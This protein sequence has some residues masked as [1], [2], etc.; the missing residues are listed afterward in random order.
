[1][2]NKYRLMS[3]VIVLLSCT[4]AGAVFIL[5][6][7]RIEAIY[8]ESA[9]SAILESKKAHL[10]HTVKNQITRIEAARKRL[11]DDELVK[12]EIARD[13]RNA[14]YPM[15]SY[16]WVTEVLNYDGGEDYAIRRIHPNLRDTEGQF[17]S[18][19]MTDIKGGKPYQTELEGVKNHGS[20]FLSYYFKGPGSDEISEKVTYAE[21]YRDFN[22]IVSMGVHMDDIVA[23]VE[24]ANSKSHTLISH[25]IAFFMLAL[26]VLTGISALTVLFLERKV[27]FD[28]KKLLEEEANMDPLTG[29]LSRRAGARALSG[30]FAAFRGGERESPMVALFD[31]DNFKNINDVCGHGGGDEVL[32]QTVERVDGAVRMSDRLFRWGG[33][34]F[35]LI[36]EGVAPDKAAKVAENVVRA[37]ASEAFFTGKRNADITLSMGA[38]FFRLG[39]E[40]YEDALKRADEALYE[41]KTKG[42]NRVE[43][44]S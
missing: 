11:G 24:D 41:A 40:G 17:L 14:V 26:A 28:S 21:L 3:V 20:L 38:A 44:A 13:I 35:L 19:E 42:R 18:T 37:V 10:R 8:G 33:D 29:A 43:V 36:M 39:D 4:V 31:I 15:D 12:R 1:M 5:F 27:H 6:D 9:R 22:W 16:I 23:V 34:E 30:S 2:R 25:L 32:K 7:G